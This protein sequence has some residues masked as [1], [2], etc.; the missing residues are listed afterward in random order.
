MAGVNLNFVLTGT[1]RSASRALKGVGAQ[2][3]STHGKLGKLGGAGLAVAGGVAAAAGAAVIAGKAMW[4][5]AGAAMEDEAAQKRLATGLRNTAGATDKAIAKAEA[6]I[7]KQGE[8]KGV[9]DDA[10]RP[11]LQRLAQSTGDVGEA[12]DLATLAMDASAGTG[13][14]LES[15]AAALAKAHDG[16]AGALARLG[17]KTK[18][19]S[20]K[21]LEFDDI[22]K[23]MGKTFKGQAAESADTLEGKMGRLK[24]MFSEAKESLG[25]KLLPVLERFGTWIFDKGLP[26]LKDMADKVM[27]KLRDVWDHLKQTV[28]DNKPG[29]ERIGDIVKKVADFVV[30]K[31]VPA[32]LDFEKVILG[33]V[34][35]AL[36]WLG[37]HLDEIGLA[38]VRGARFVVGGFKAMYTGVT[39]VLEGILTVA[40]RTMG[41]IPGIG[42]KI[43]AAKKGFSEFRDHTIDKIGDVED[44]LKSA[45]R[46]LKNY[47]EQARKDHVA[48][49][50][51]DIKDQQAKIR[52]AK[53]SLL[54]PDL[55]KERKAQIKADIT[56][57]QKGVRDAKSELNKVKDKHVTISATIT[58][59]SVS[60]GVKNKL[61]HMP[62]GGMGGSGG[63]GGGPVSVGHGLMAATHGVG[64]LGARFMARG[65]HWSWGRRNGIGMHDGADVVAP[66]GTPVYATRSGSIVR[67]GHSGWA[68]NHVVWQ[69]GGTRYIYAHLSSIARSSGSVSAGT[70]LGRV[71]SSGNAFGAH[72]H[73]QASRSGRYVN[74]AAYL[75]EGG[76][77]R[78]R[79]GGVPVVIGE[80]RYDEAVVPLPRGA[81][82]GG[83]LHVHFDGV[84][85]GSKADAGRY[86]AEALREHKRASG[87][88]LGLA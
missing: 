23:N 25:A 26:A 56:K 10:L 2:A 12:Q 17:I 47:D 75:A 38:A 86:I 58:S 82:L 11:A 36:G 51:A 69:S 8:S 85:I 59:I 84:I 15:V 68:G 6:W 9:A 40:E 41:W 14:S 63:D 55:T 43:K 7:T 66:R 78:R 60:A 54:D 29:L 76:I 20:G 88:A 3:E 50:K 34:I 1:D 39:G 72:L 73:V 5:M 21:T 4:D 62:V 31:V 42:D 74:P 22:V 33:N 44:G 77:V 87:T 35:K 16:N 83:D 45:E 52:D 70:M 57:L 24:L 27:P 80:G 49:L 32:W 67:T 48:K 81:G 28:E 30:T 53:R 65:P 19:A 13:K 61:K 37:D 71:G 46:S 79:P 64:H 18:D